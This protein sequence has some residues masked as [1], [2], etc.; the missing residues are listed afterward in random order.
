MK[1]CCLLP[2]LPS[3][4]SLLLVLLDVQTFVH[5]FSC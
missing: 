3:D 4:M 1:N 5:I 2:I